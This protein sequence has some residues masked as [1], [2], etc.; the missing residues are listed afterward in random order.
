MPLLDDV[1]AHLRIPAGD[2]DSD[3]LLSRLIA[4]AEAEC[5]R[6][7]GLAADAEIDQPDAITGVFLMVQADYDGD[8]EKRNI[9]RAA[10]IAL[11]RDHRENA[12]GL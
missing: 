6:F 4:S 7:I 3:V 9:Y 11:W 12:G 5:R 8:P 2:T 1:K 10:A